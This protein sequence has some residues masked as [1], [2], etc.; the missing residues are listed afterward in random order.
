MLCRKDWQYC[1]KN[2]NKRM[3][4][5]LKC[6]HFSRT[7]LTE[8]YYLERSLHFWFS[9]ILLF[10]CSIYKPNTPYSNINCL[11][12]ECDFHL[13][14]PKLGTAFEICTPVSEVSIITLERGVWNLNGV[15]YGGIRNRLNLLQCRIWKKNMDLFIFVLVL[16][17]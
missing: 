10:G 12:R 3:Q 13:G 16:S 4:V 15:A 11:H 14:L 2:V 6:W 1:I 9:G 5:N 17:P 7:T 8:L